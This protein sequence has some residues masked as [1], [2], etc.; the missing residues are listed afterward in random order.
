MD[1]RMEDRRADEAK[2]SDPRSQEHM[3]CRCLL[4]RMW[5]LLAPISTDSARTHCIQSTSRQR[6]AEENVSRTA[7]K[8]RHP[9]M[10]AIR[11]R[12][13]DA[14]P[15]VQASHDVP[16]ERVPRLEKWLSRGV[17]SNHD[18]RDP[19]RGAGTLFWPPVQ[20]AAWRRGPGRA[21]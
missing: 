9:A 16:C 11:I 20:R 7:C 3:H 10:E 13:T 14:A 18:H 19:G 2:K 12:R 5:S 15:D 17:D 8:L 4:P 21:P 6:H 1:R